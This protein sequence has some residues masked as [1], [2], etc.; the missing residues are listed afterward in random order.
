LSKSLNTIPIR[1]N[2]PVYSSMHSFGNARSFYSQDYRKNLIHYHPDGISVY[3][4]HGISVYHST[5][6]SVY[7]FHHDVPPLYD[8]TQ[9]TPKYIGSAKVKQ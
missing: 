8:V 1:A 2:P 9:G 7:H 4:Y 6:N 5:R 3:H